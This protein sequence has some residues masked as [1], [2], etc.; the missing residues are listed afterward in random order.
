MASSAV[1]E[2]SGLPPEAQTEK[3][4][5]S[6]AQ[7]PEQS[8]ETAGQ[9]EE[10]ES[11][12]E[13]QGSPSPSDSHSEG[14]YSGSE[15]DEQRDP[16]ITEKSQPPLPNEPLPGH[17]S[18]GPPLP[19]EP[20][21]SDPT[22]PPLP[23]EPI[24]E[25]EDDGWEFHWN[26][27]DQSYWFYSRFTGA[28]QKENPRVPVASTSTANPPTTAPAD[29]GP[30]PPPADG[31]TALSNPTSVAGGYNPA[32]HGDYDENAWYAQNLHGAAGAGAGAG[33]GGSNPA[34]PTGAGGGAADEYASAALFNRHTGQWQTAEQGAERHSDEAKSRRQMRAFFDVDAAANM[35]DGRSLKAER[36]GIKPSRSELK[37]FKEKR[38]AKK[39]EKRRAWLRD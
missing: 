17:D 28:W 3:P 14:E 18:T 11:P 9:Q 8:P 15:A 25:P 35:H 5:E 33:A 39:E 31:S 32:I 2:A 38:R 6:P 37:A 34:D 36:S 10:S 27:N 23:A 4:N 30:A 21:P 26:P 20:L 1:A 12:A 19:N 24:P 22:A 16:K 7:S 13:P 29:P